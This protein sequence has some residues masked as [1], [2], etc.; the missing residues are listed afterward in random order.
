MFYFGMTAILKVENHV[1]C[2]LDGLASFSKYTET[3]FDK[4]ID[5]AMFRLIQNSLLLT[6]NSL[7]YRWI[8]FTFLQ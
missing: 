1:C 6:V 7:M 8:Q 5:C 4:F 3:P 2:S